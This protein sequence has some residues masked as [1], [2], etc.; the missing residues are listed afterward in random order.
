M[1]IAFVIA[2]FGFWYCFYLAVR[3]VA[4]SRETADA[5]R[6]WSPVDATIVELQS[7]S[8]EVCSPPPPPPASFPP[9]SFSSTSS[10][11]R[12]LLSPTPSEPGSVALQRRQLLSCTTR[13]RIEGSYTYAW[14]GRNY[15]SDQFSVDGVQGD[16]SYRDEYNESL[17]NG[18]AVVAWVSPEHPDEAVLQRS[19]S[20]TGAGAIV[21]LIFFALFLCCWHAISCGFTCMGLGMCRER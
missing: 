21:G 20:S 18:T 2:G 17:V 14:H 8:E 16:V 10:Y 3:S 12:R 9:P 19:S 11:W 15:T 6:S 5:A 13:H 1:C 7:R 4:H